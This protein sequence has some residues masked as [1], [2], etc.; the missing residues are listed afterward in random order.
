MWNRKMSSVFL[1]LFLCGT[2]FAENNPLAGSAY[3]QTNQ[4]YSPPLLSGVP[5]PSAPVSNAFTAYS[6]D[7]VVAAVSGLGTGNGTLNV[8]GV[9]GSVEKVYL[10]WHGIDNGGYGAV[11]DN[12]TVSFNGNSVTGVS[13]GDATTNCWGSGSSRAFRADV[14]PYVSGDGAYSLSGTA[15]KPNHNANGASLV[16]LFNDGNPSNNRDFVFFEG[17]DSNYPE[18]F[19]GE[20]DGWH[21]TLAG[22]SYGGGSVSAELHVGDGQS[23]ADNSLTFVGSGGPVVIPDTTSRYDGV[24]VPSAGHS[25]AG[26]GN[27]WDVHTFDITSAFGAPGAET[28]Q[29]DG[30]MTVSD[31]LGLVLLLVDLDAGDAP[32]PPECG[33]GNLDP[34]EECDD[35]NTE[36]GDGCS[37]QCQIEEPTD[38]CAILNCDDGNI[39]TTDSCDPE[40]GCVSEPV[41]CDDRDVCNGN[42]VCDPELGCINGAPLVC[43]DNDV[44]NGIET[45]DAFLGCVAGTPLRCDDGN[46]CDGAEMC[47]ALLGCQEGTPLDCDDEDSC[48]T[49][50][51]D[52]KNGCASVATIESRACDSCED[53]T[54]NDND[55]RVDCRDEGCATLNDACPFAVVGTR[56]SGTVVNLGR[57]AAVLDDAGG[58]AATCANANSK[59]RKAVLVEGTFV[60]NGDSKFA[61]GPNPTYLGA[62]SSDGGTESLNG[63][64]IPVVGP[65]LQTLTDP[66]NTYVN[67]TGALAE[68]GYCLDA[69]ADLPAEAAYLMTLAGDVSL[70]PVD[71]PVGSAP[72]IVL[73][74][75][76]Q[77]IIDVEMLQMG[78]NT[79]LVLDGAANTVA[80]I[81]IADRGRFKVGTKAQVLVSGGLT[82]D[83]VLWVV[84]GTGQA[85]LGALSQF[86]GTILAPER[87]R[88]KAG[89]FS[90]VSGA[91]FT[92]KVLMKRQATVTHYPFVSLV[93]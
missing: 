88:I 52:S 5:A 47:D 8:S 6:A 1:A 19:P 38:P 30:Q 2:V 13:L 91:I 54:D 29:M 50:T 7:K 43:N 72:L 53:G 68:F 20:T 58:G 28:L 76:G 32:P 69:V 80:V 4:S 35:G 70:G 87:R 36:N 59:G 86:S 24:S 78:L 83:R 40:V 23:F 37:S 26:N 25:R 85:K 16:V 11:Y 41:I 93:E 3:S 89:A 9:S 10:Y 55:A 92:S 77:Q 51:C 81:R 60:V 67:R 63:T 65:L 74:G 12:E 34:G 71:L 66:A 22:I 17:N 45:C 27:L 62:F 44:C 39:C 82:P 49:D 21:A 56:D 46:V 57:E 31:C 84:A 90:Q 14:T 61:S 33:D 48:T 64:T 18:G 79:Q 75:S 42:E 73:L 15:S